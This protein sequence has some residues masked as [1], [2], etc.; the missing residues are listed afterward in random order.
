MRNRWRRFQGY[1]RASRFQIVDNHD[2]LIAPIA[3]AGCVPKLQVDRGCAR[4]PPASVK[5]A[6]LQKRYRLPSHLFVFNTLS[7]MFL[8]SF[9]F[10]SYKDF[11]QATKK[12]TEFYLRKQ[13]THI[14]F[15]VNCNLMHKCISCNTIR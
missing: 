3:H 13:N 14:E 1:E 2:F 11:Y 10:F 7:G 8:Q 6:T 15:I 5:M 9:D 4:V 12:N